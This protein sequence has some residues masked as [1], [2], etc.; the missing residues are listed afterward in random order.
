MPH[1]LEA[2]V[3]SA[4]EL[5]AELIKL[6]AWRL[7]NDA[8]E[9]TFE[10]ASFLE[11]IAFVNRVAVVAEQYNHHPDFEIH[12]KKV[13][14]RLWTHKQHAITRADVVVAAAIDAIA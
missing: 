6:P 7:V 12:W 4:D 5:R 13:T 11:A 1:A 9:R 10:Y 14:L 3:L 8:L 2:A